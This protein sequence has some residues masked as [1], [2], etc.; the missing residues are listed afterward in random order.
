[1]PSLMSGAP[2]AIPSDPDLKQSELVSDLVASPPGTKR[3]LIALLDR[4]YPQE[5][6]LYFLRELVF[7]SADAICVS[8]LE[9]RL[10]IVNP[11]F[12]EL[13]GR[14]MNE[15]LGRRV[16]EIIQTE[17]ERIQEIEAQLARGIPQKDY[18]FILRREGE[19]TRVLSVS[20]TP[21]AHPGDGVYRLCVHVTRDVTGR[22]EL[23]RQVAEWQERARQYLYSLHPPEIAEAMVEGRLEARNLNVSVLFTDVSGFTHF[24]SRVPASEAAGALQRYFT[25]MTQIVLDHQGWVD[26]FVGDSIMAL[27]GVPGG[28]PDHALQAVRAGQQMIRD[29][30][31]LDLPW[32]HKVGIASGQVI[33]GNIGSRQKPTYTAI[34]DPVNLAN[35]LTQTARPGEVLVCPTTHAAAGTGF[36]YEPLGDLEIR[37]YGYCKV[38]R[39]LPA[40]R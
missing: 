34:G 14:S 8:D 39:L 5:F 38:F 33:A 2:G 4:H 31:E 29:M 7:Q 3:A 21:M 32:R 18:E 9:G 37:G 25:A 40:E 28:S 27:F 6:Q 30:R 36:P 22:R 13:V 17:E 24:T 19:T 16:S 12:C 35:R 11:A 26:K 1:M 23:E 15:V 20:M 10:L